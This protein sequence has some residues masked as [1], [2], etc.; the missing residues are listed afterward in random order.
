MLFNILSALAFIRPEIGYCQG[1]NFIVG[2][3]INFIDNE[4]KCF[5]IFLSFIDNFE[6]NFLYLKN[7]PDYSIRVYQLNFYIKE[8]FPD[9]SFH[10]K[11]NQI[12]NIFM[13]AMK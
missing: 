8:Y 10:F 13:Y 9:L 4:E 3:L 7:M 11:K 12:K 1:M 6:M 2:A 5:W